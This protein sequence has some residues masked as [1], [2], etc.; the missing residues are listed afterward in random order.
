MATLTFTESGIP[1]TTP[2][3]LVVDNPDPGFFVISSEDTITGLGIG[4]PT[5]SESVRINASVDNLQADT[6]A[7]DDR[8][9]IGG[10]VINSSIELGDGRDNFLVGG[11]FINSGVDGGD[12]RDVLRFNGSVEGS[13]ISGGEGDDLVGF[14]GDVNSSF[15]QLGS[16]ND[17][18]RFAG[19]VTNTRLDLG[20]GADVVRISD[21]N[22]DTTGLV[23]EG[24]SDDDVLFIGSSE[25]A[26]GG[27]N[28][29]INVDDPT[30]Q[31]I[32]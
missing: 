25:Y 21:P 17:E 6:G 32:F 31:R 18:V 12:G 3:G 27:G 1:E 5:I 26:F 30:D 28:T 23:I 16:D 8:L 7:G 29:W 14:F 15:I 22:A 2:E 20:G 19:D 4:G 11:D 24:A 13:Y 9:L 10:D